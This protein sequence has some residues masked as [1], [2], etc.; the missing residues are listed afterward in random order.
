MEPREYQLEAIDRIA[1]AMGRGKKR[2]LLQAPTGSGKTIISSNIMQ[3]AVNKGSQ[4][5]FLADRRKLV[6]QKSEKL[7]IHGVPHGILMSGY[8]PDHAAPIQVASIQSLWERAVKDKYWRL[9][10]ADLIIIDEA[11]KSLGTRYERLVTELYPDSWLI[12]MTATPIRSDGRGLGD[13]YDELVQVRSVLELQREG[14]LVGTRYYAP[15]KPDL[16]NVRVSKHTGDYNE[17]D[18]ARAMEEDVVLVG[19]ILKHYRQHAADR[20]AVVFCSSVKH[21]VF[22]AN[23]FNKAGIPAEHIDG[24]TYHI[25]R[26]RIYEDIRS[27]RT[28][29]ITNCQVLTEGWDEPSISA[30]ILARPTKSLGMY[31]QMAGRVLRPYE[32]KEDA[33]ILDHSGATSLGFVEDEHL[34]DLETSK[35]FARKRAALKKKSEPITCPECSCVFRARN[36]PMCGWEIPGPAPKA[37]YMT[38]D[39]LKALESPQAKDLKAQKREF[40]ARLLG[41]ANE[42]N[43]KRGWAN[44]S[45]RAKYGVWPK[46]GEIKPMP[47]NM[48]T[49]NWAR[50]LAIKRAKK[51]EAGRQQQYREREK[52]AAERG[53]E[54]V[55]SSA[56]GG[57][58]GRLFRG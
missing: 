23:M 55:D 35:K 10:H 48:E 12:G 38:R 19:D 17:E 16:K 26:H 8:S 40:Y 57:E 6:E 54:A 46:L 56:T 34:W 14:F 36:C 30:C 39:E 9:P 51:L 18:L 5:L 58:Q 11:H 3:R 32:G 53:K 47:P 49:Y 52:N 27:G 20:K 28:Q 29:V 15:S 13:L 24:G 25:E 42:R 41:L 45:Y 2:V 37:F 21:S 31:L 44:H 7:T 50:H 33:L 4:A 22:V 1:D 43:Y